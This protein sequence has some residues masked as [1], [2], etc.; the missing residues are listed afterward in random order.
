MWPLATNRYIPEC[1]KHQKQLCGKHCGYGV[2]LCWL[3]I[4]CCFNVQ[5]ITGVNLPITM[6][7]DMSCQRHHVWVILVKPPINKDKVSC[8]ILIWRFGRVSNWMFPLSCKLLLLSVNLT[9]LTM[10]AHGE[11]KRFNQKPITKR[12]ETGDPNPV[13]HW[14]NKLELLI[15]CQQLLYDLKLINV[16]N[17]NDPK[18]MIMHADIT[19]FIIY[20]I[21]IYIYIQYILWYSMIF[22]CCWFSNSKTR[23][24]QRAQHGWGAKLWPLLW[25]VELP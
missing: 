15:K 21:Y 25:M 5:L 17:S 24:T 13:Y 16:W 7:I 2:C 9:A 10:A 6:R 12:Q 20:N 19:L 3:F 18:Y 23:Q 8:Q 11:A 14:V 4:I 1:I 22:P